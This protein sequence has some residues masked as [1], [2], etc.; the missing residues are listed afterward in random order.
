MAFRYWK[1]DPTLSVCNLSYVN[2]D[3]NGLPKY[4]Y[5]SGSVAT[6]W[7]ALASMFGTRELVT[8][9]YVT[10]QRRIA[11]ASQLRDIWET[12]DPL[13]PFA[14]S[15]IEKFEFPLIGE[16]H[17][18][19]LDRKRRG[20]M[21]VGP[22]VVGSCTRTVNSKINTAAASS[23]ASVYGGGN[24]GNAANNPLPSTPSSAPLIEGYRCYNA[25]YT[26]MYEL[27]TFTQPTYLTSPM[28]NVPNAVPAVDIETSVVT[29]A[30]AACNKG[31]YDL[32]TEIAEMPQTVAFL[33]DV[34]TRIIG[35]TR[36]HQQEVSRLKKLIGS[37]T[38]TRF[39]KKLAALELSFRY[40]VM[41]L[42]YSVQDVQKTLQGLEKTYAEYR[43]RSD[44][45]S[46]YLWETVYPVASML[47][48]DNPVCS[49]RCFIKANYTPDTIARAL[50]NAI[51]MNPV[52]TL[53]ELRPL[54]FVV[55]W[56]FNVGDT[57]VALTS[58]S[59]AAMI[60][61]TYSVR[62]AQAT[63]KFSHN[64]SDR[65][66]PITEI[67]LDSYNRVV[68]NPSDH[69]GLALNVNMNWKRYLDGSALLLQKSLRSLRK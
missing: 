7:P 50:I 48:G 21:V 26:V 10:E 2:N 4:K 40:A 51:G 6:V 24:F 36:V 57:I 58:S 8:Y 15:S 64:P 38:A 31:T 25:T 68:I 13:K 62:H 37:M 66:Y 52:A 5:V 16:P 67:V 47:V 17:S 27:R 43:E 59:D 1:C 23:V 44:L 65:T 22:V 20:E 18:N 61:S 19:F 54:S 12:T 14:T 9:D 45:P 30:L 29:S 55:D 35:V 33:S 41:P 3:P 53:W 60:A 28:I 46:P 49:H 42:F 32:L 63:W 39:A 34:V 11:A 69:I 56:A